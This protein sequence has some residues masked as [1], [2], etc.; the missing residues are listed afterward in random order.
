[1]TR[2]RH[3]LRRATL[4]LRALPL[5][6]VVLSTV[7]SA[8]AQKTDTRAVY[9]R[10]EAAVKAG[11][12]TSAQARAMLA[13]LTRQTT[14]RVPSRATKEAAEIASLRRRIAA[15]RRA[16]SGAR[17]PAARGVTAR[18]SAERR[19]AGEDAKRARE[20]L[21]KARKEIA[22]AVKAKKITQ[23]DARK[24]LAAVTKDVQKKLV[25]GVMR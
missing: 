10:L 4:W 17:R 25:A 9:K 15:A 22:A 13:T 21:A 12:I 23:A 19:P 18:R 11:E 5:I 8:P 24:K 7:A 14:A 20:Y 1:M 3:P 2:D 16:L 6:A